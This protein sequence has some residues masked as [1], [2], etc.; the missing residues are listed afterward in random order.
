V[1]LE[2]KECCILSG[3]CLDRYEVVVKLGDADVTMLKSVGAYEDVGCLR[4]CHLLPG[5]SSLETGDDRANAIGGGGGLHW[6]CLMMVE[7]S[8]NL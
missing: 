2:I 8:N 7:V 5:T 6:V 1:H 3:C 4:Q